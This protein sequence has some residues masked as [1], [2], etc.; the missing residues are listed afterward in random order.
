MTNPRETIEVMTHIRELG[1][2]FSLDD[3]GINY[4]SMR[5]LKNLPIS[6]LK[7]DYIFVK[8]MVHD[9]NDLAIINTILQLAD[10]LGISTV[11]E[12]VEN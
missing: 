12:G 5:Y 2:S 3:F 1:V 8:D 11:A 6:Q 4:S 9:K 10:G 7:I